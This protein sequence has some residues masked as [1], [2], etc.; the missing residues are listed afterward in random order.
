MRCTYRAAIGGGISDNWL[1]SIYCLYCYY[2]L[3]CV[4]VSPK[5]SFPLGGILR[6]ERNFSLTCDF[7]G[8][9]N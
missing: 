7:S 6:A 2:E 1:Y 4:R 3:L 9:T 5:A 8:A